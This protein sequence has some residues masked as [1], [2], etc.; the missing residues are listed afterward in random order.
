M[1]SCDIFSQA[2]NVAG[3][4]LKG[5]DTAGGSNQ[6][7]GS[8]RKRP[9]MRA[10]V[11]DDKTGLNHRRK[12]CHYIRLMLAAPEPGFFRY[13]EVHPHALRWASLHLHPESAA[14][15]D[16]AASE[17]LGCR[18]AA[19]RERPAE[20]AAIEHIPLERHVHAVDEEERG[21]QSGFAV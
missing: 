20:Q 12:R 5:N 21:V 7:C 10:D 16:A 15:E 8:Q 6:P 3:I 13:A 19:T 4:G 14:G 2:L 18:K 11:V 9:E 17:I 1:I